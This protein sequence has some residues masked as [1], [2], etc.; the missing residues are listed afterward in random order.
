MSE[1]KR[2]PV[3]LHNM[4]L[5]AFLLF[6]LTSVAIFWQ[7]GEMISAVRSSG[8]GPAVMVVL[9]LPTLGLLVSG[10]IAFASLRASA[11]TGGLCLLPIIGFYALAL[12][13]METF[14]LIHDWSYF[15]PMS[16]IVGSLAFVIREFT[17]RESHA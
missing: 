17:K 4:K 5:I 9:W 3:V 14:S 2:L 12:F 10:L 16:G 6:L 1:T 15:V 7:S 13:S 11:I 8:G